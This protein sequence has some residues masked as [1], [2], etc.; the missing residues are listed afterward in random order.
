MT[1]QSSQ[2]VARPLVRLRWAV[3]AA[4]TLGIAASVAA[5]ILHAQPHPVSQVIA[6]W[7]S[8]ALM[9]T[10]EIMSRVPSTGPGLAAARTAVTG[11]IAVIA[12]YVS[13]FHMV[14][15]ATR[16]G[17]TGVAA[18]LLPFSV[19]G[20]VVV[21]SISL[22]DIGAHLAATP[23]PEARTAQASANFEKK[24]DGSCAQS[25]LTRAEPSL[26]PTAHAAVTSP[27]SAGAA[28]TRHGANPDAAARSG[29]LPLPAPV[30]DTTDH[31]RAHNAFADSDRN[32]LDGDEAGGMPATPSDTRE[33]VEYWR[34]QDSTLH[35]AQIAARIG[36]SERTVR[37][38]LRTAAVPSR[39]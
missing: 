11:V 31:V 23:R 25:P 4:F 32:A 37:R 13:Y 30:D 24:K 2:P 6:A 5:N 7:P 15:V 19:D 9:C 1:P 16:Y 34:R 26:H 35:P 29:H 8:V 33:A 22:V 21:A 28:P 10:V 17:E 18:Y 14:G 38:Y 39:S 27:A 36:R 3:R 12:A 20:L